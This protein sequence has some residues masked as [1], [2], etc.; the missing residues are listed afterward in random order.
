[1]SNS[2][3]NTYAD[4]RDENG[5]LQCN[6]C[7]YKPPVKAKK[8]KNGNELKDKNGKVILYQNKSTFKYHLDNHKGQLPHICKHCDK[9]FLHKNVLETHIAAIHPDDT[10]KV[11]TFCCDVPGCSF[12]SWQKG[13]LIIHK[14]RKHC[15]TTCQ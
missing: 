9:G 12:S 2:S 15:L 7:G 14:S 8:D 10:M 1:M 11:K 4:K 3:K 6:I 13:N 5:L